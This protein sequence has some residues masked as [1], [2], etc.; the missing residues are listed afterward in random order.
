MHEADE[1]G[2]SL[3]AWA[4]HAR[5]ETKKWTVQIAKIASCSSLATN[6]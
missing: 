6:W 3:Q 4:S 2:N 1:K 5:L